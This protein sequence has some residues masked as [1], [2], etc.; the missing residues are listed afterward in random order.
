MWT[1]LYPILFDVRT[2]QLVVGVTWQLRRFTISYL[3][4]EREARPSYRCAVTSLQPRGGR[5]MYRDVVA[6][7]SPHGVGR[8]TPVKER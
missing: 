6:A 8:N 2:D 4:L 3:Q 5:Q 7:P 1:R